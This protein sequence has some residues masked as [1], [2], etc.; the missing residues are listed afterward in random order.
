MLQTNKLTK[1]QTDKNP[2]QNQSQMKLKEASAKL[3]QKPLLHVGKLSQ[4]NCEMMAYPAP[5]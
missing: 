1:K 2:Q 4:Q 5:C 3:F